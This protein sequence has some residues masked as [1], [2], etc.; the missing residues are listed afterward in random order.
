MYIYSMNFKL[1]MYVMNLWAVFVKY[2]LCLIH[3]PVSRGKL[4]QIGDQVKYTYF[5]SVFCD[6]FNSSLPFYVHLLHLLQIC[7]YRVKRLFT[8]AFQ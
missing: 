1:V 7:C 8:P 4:S 2:F 3:K 5:S 6:I